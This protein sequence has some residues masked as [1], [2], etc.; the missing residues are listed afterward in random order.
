MNVYDESKLYKMVEK[1]KAGAKNGTLKLD[2]KVYVFTFNQ[3]RDHYVIT[4]D[5]EVECR[6]NERNLSKA[7]AWFKNWMEN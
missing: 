6:L 2:G 1:S 5:G 3:E 4:L 7:K